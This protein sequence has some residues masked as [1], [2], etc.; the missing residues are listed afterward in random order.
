MYSDRDEVDIDLTKV[1]GI[2]VVYEPVTLHNEHG[3]FEFDWSL[4]F[5]MEEGQV[6]FFGYYMSIDEA[7]DKAASYALQCWD[8]TNQ[9]HKRC[10]F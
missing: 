2:I 4:K 8:P 3:D 6:I 7:K 1:M 10:P 9:Y 5:T